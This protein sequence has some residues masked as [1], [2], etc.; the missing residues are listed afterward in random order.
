[1][2]SGVDA[3]PTGGYRDQLRDVLGPDHEEDELEA[4]EVERSLVHEVEE[5]E[6]FAA[7][8]E[9]EAGVSVSVAC[10]AVRVCSQCRWTLCSMSKCC[11]RTSRNLPCLLRHLHLLRLLQGR[12]VTLG[13]GRRP[14]PLCQDRTFT[15]Q[16]PDFA[17]SRLSLPGRRPQRA[18][19]RCTPISTS[20]CLPHHPISLRC[21]DPRP[22]RTSPPISHKTRQPMRSHSHR[23]RSY[24]GPSSGSLESICTPCRLRRRP[25]FWVPSPSARRLS[26]PPM[27]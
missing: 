2:Y 8:I 27:G 6:K 13:M 3:D 19:L 22:S 12:P 16:S 15:L 20:L 25:R 10:L 14:T 23:E 24:G 21:P 7:T 26:S 11:L 9:D 1:M 4:E 17:R 5:N 18:L